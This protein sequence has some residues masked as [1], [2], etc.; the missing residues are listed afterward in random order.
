MDHPKLLIVD[1]DEAI[2]TQLRWALAQ[3][4]EV[5]V[6]ADRQTAL[7]VFRQEHPHVVTLDL[8]LPPHPHGVEEGFQVLSDILQ[9]EA[10]VKVVV[11]TGR[12]ER[13]HALEAIGQ[14]AYDFL[15]KPIQIDELRLLLRR[16]SQVYQLEQEYQDP[17]E[18]SSGTRPSGQQL[19]AWC[20]RPSNW[21]PPGS[22]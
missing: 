19:P 2:R 22:C 10:N 21:A 16:A 4:Y 3:E 12:E 20:R 5:F 9:S 18:E 13:E 7:D 17:A 6:A 8:G 14:G 15:R 1:D 11:I